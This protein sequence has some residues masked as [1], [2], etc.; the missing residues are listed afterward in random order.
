[1][2]Q[3][4]IVKSNFGMYIST[5]TFIVDGMDCVL[6]DILKEYIE[7]SNNNNRLNGSNIEFSYNVIDIEN[8]NRYDF[9][10]K[11]KNR[12]AIEKDVNERIKAHLI[13]LQKH[14]DKHR[15]K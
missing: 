10:N 2:K 14:A 13:K 5:E 3:I 4:N 7:L 11:I 6:H 9:Y 12:I 15:K 8:I 1:M